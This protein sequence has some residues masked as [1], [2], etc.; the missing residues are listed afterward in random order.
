MGAPQQQRMDG[1]DRAHHSMHVQPL[2][3]FM[4]PGN[5]AGNDFRLHNQKSRIHRFTPLPPPPAGR[6]RN[7]HLR[8][9]TLPVPMRLEQLRALMN[10]CMRLARGRRTRAGIGD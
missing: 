1:L 3:S 6:P 7:A 5:L 9:K 2:W 4:G 8:I 10:V